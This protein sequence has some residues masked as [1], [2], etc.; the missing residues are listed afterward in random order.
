MSKIILALLF[1]A[2]TATAVIYLVPQYKVNQDLK[3]QNEV[4]RLELIRNQKEINKKRNMIRDLHDNPAA[5]DRI[6]REKFGM[7]KPGERVYKFTD[8]D[9]FK[10][11]NTY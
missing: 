10:K 2:S 11:S 6:A 1:I 7:C 4:T 3:K 8:E 9:L 5:I